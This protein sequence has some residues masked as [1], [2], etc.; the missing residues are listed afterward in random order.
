MEGISYYQ[1]IINLSLQDD[2][3]SK[4]TIKENVCQVSFNH[5]KLFDFKY[6][7]EFIY[8]SQRGLFSRL[9]NIVQVIEKEFI[10]F[11]MINKFRST[12]K[13]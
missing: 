5:K 6:E 10:D 9:N 3:V 1:A 13:H 7:I 4:I 2:L 8:F 11:D 12:V